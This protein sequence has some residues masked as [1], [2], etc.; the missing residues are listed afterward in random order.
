FGNAL[1]IQSTESLSQSARDQ[2]PL[3][4]LWLWLQREGTLA[5]RAPIDIRM[6]VGFNAGKERIPL[7]RVYRIAGYSVYYRQGNEFADPRAV[8]T[9]GFAAEELL[10]RVKVIVHED[11][12]DDKNFALPWEI[13]ESVVTPL[14]SLITVEF[15]RHRRDDENLRQAMDS[16]AEER[17]LSRE[18][19][20]L[21][22]EAERLFGSETLNEAKEKILALMPSYPAYHRQFQRQVAGQHAATVLEAKLS[23][24]LAYYRYFDTIASLAEAVRD[25][26][27]LIQ[28]LK[29]FPHPERDDRLK[30]YLEE[31]KAKYSASGI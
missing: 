1:G 19:N 8:V 29:Q 31:L 4:M 27:T 5:L 14:G 2:A 20:A 3:S 17:R 9:V 28:D 22:T 10:R 26:R 6:A 25:L 16:L 21:V 12:H 7:E 18:L 30:L 11:L 13:E 15:F 23:H 24:D